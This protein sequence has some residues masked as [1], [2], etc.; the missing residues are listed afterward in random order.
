MKLSA[1]IAG[2]IIVSLALV[3]VARSPSINASDIWEQFK[4]D[5]ELIQ[6]KVYRIDWE[7][8]YSNLKVVY[9]Q[10]ED[11]R[12]NKSIPDP[13]LTTLK[14]QQRAAICKKDWSKV[15][16]LQRLID[17]REQELKNQ[18]DGVVVVR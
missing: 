4:D 9:R 8:H 18:K 15:E 6:S 17:S 13:M 7:K 3:V 12:L 5:I 11:G 1:R 14:N 16:K 10:S 2:F